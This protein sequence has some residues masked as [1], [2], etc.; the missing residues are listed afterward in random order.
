VIALV[1]ILM[2]L[3]A[4]LTIETM[5]I[6]AELDAPESISRAKESALKTVHAVIH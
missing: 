3:S 5:R 4:E 2:H 1:K 6:H